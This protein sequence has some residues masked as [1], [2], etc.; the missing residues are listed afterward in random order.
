MYACRGWRH[1]IEPYSNKTRK[2]STESP[3]PIPQVFIASSSS[4]FFKNKRTPLYKYNGDTGISFS[5]HDIALIRCD[6]VTQSK[7]VSANRPKFESDCAGRIWAAIMNRVQVWCLHTPRVRSTHHCEQ[8]H[9]G[10]SFDTRF[11]PCQFENRAAW[12]ARCRNPKTCMSL[13]LGKSAALPF[14]TGNVSVCRRIANEVNWIGLSFTDGALLP[15]AFLDPCFLSL[16]QVSRSQSTGHIQPSFVPTQINVENCLLCPNV[17]RRRTLRRDC[18]CRC[19][20]LSARRRA[21]LVSVP[22]R[23]RRKVTHTQVKTL[24]PAVVMSLQ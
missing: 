20:A 5:V 22:H 3:K 23:A 9:R 7:S 13:L 21:S 19:C 8:H 18:C 6:A 17:S 10:T 2:S 15:T 16:S 11:H 12:V 24:D 4:F 14:D 1:P